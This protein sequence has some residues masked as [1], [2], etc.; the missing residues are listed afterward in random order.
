LIDLQKVRK[1]GAEG[2]DKHQI[3]LK[4]LENVIKLSINKGEFIKAIYL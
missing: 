2:I 1:G 4:R 3:L